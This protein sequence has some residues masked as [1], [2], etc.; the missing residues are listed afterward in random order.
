MTKLNKNA[1]KTISNASLC[2]KSLEYKNSFNYVTSR[3]F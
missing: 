1:H 2:L 3:L